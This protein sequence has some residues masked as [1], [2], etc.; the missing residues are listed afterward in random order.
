MENNE[1]QKTESWKEHRK[2]IIL[3]KSHLISDDKKQQ[4]I[5]LT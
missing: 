5:L 2:T 3:K 4:A 1:T